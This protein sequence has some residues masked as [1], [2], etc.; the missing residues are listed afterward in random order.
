MN[1]HGAKGGC[2]TRAACQHCA[3][4]VDDP[5]L[6]EAEIPNLTSFG[7]AYSSA[8]GYAGICRKLDLFLDPMLAEHC[9]S[10]SFRGA[11]NG[12]E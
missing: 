4:F 8:R 9:P 3:H 6:I 2:M 1:H 5:A 10:F 11:V 12:K 7:S